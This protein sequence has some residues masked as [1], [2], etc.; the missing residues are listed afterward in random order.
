ML[1]ILFRPVILLWWL[2][3]SILFGQ[4]YLIHNYTADDG[5]P[6]SA[7]YDVIQDSLGQI[8]AATRA[9][10]AINNGQAWQWTP[11]VAKHSSRHFKYFVK[12]SAGRLMLVRQ[13]K[14][15][16]IYNYNGSRWNI[17]KTFDLPS[18]E[19]SQPNKVAVAE[20][21]NKRFC[22]I[23]SYP[24][25]VYL[26]IRNQWQ[27]LMLSDADTLLTVNAL[28]PWRNGWFCASNLG[29]HY[30]SV[31]GRQ[32]KT[33]HILASA[34]PDCKAI[35]I[36]TSTPF[37][38]SF[39]TLPSLWLV[40]EGG[41]A[42]FE[43]D[44]LIRFGPPIQH[45]RGSPSSIAID[46]LGDVYYSNGIETWFVDKM[47]TKVTSIPPETGLLNTGMYIIFRDRENNMWFGGNR[48]LSKLISKRF[49]NFDERHGLLANEVSAILHAPDGSTYLGHL[50]GYT[51]LK[52]GKATAV[53]FSGLNLQAN[54]H[55]R[56]LD[57]E[58]DNLGNIW[59]ASS[60]AGLQKIRHNRILKRIKYPGENRRDCTSIKEDAQGNI[61]TSW[62]NKLARFVGGRLVPFK[63]PLL[64]FAYYRRIFEGRDS[65]V[66]FATGGKGLVAYKDGNWKL[67]RSHLETANNIFS[68]GDMGDRVWVG[69]L[70][71]LY[72]ISGD[73]LRKNRSHKVFIE[74]PTYFIATSPSGATWFGTD[75]GVLRF[76][77]TEMRHYTRRHGL[78]GLETNRAAGVF[79]DSGHLWIGTESGVSV[80]RDEFDH[81]PGK[82]PL[83][84]I[85][86]M[87]VNGKLAKTTNP[88]VLDREENSL[89]FRFRGISFVDEKS[90]YYQVRLDGY[91]NAAFFTQL[92]EVRYK[93]LPQGEY[94]LV[95]RAAN[96]YGHWS[97]PAST[98]TIEV[99]QAFYLRGWFLF[100]MFSGISSLLMLGLF[101]YSKRQ[102]V[103]HLEEKYDDKTTALKESEEKYRIL[104]ESSEDLLFITSPEGQ[105]LD[106]NPAGL[107]L[108]GY[109]S[110][111][112]IQSIDLG[113]DLLAEAHLLGQIIGELRSR[114]TIENQEITLKRK[115]GE[116]R[117]F[118]TTA[119]AIYDDTGKLHVYRGIMRDI[120]EQRRL[121][122]QLFLSEKMKS[123]G[124]LAGGIAHDFN[125]ILSSILGYASLLK[126]ELQFASVNFRYVD[127]IEKSA[128]RAAELTNQ[129]LA[130][131]RG[132]KYENQP[133]D[134]NL[135][136]EET[137]AMVR[138]TFNRAIEI[139]F[140]CHPGPL[141]VEGDASQLQQ[142]IMNLCVN[143]RDALPDGG[144]IHLQTCQTDTGE[145]ASGLAT[146]K[147]VDNGVGIPKKDLQRI[148][149]PFYTT[150]ALR[151]GTGLG[152][153]MVYGV[154]KNH[155]G[156]I[157][158]DSSVGKGTTFNITLPL[159][160]RKPKAVAREIKPVENGEGTILVVD[161]E[162]LL[163]NFLRDGLE[164]AGYRVLTA[165]N[166][167][168]ALAT[169][170]SRGKEIDLIILDMIMPKMDGK[171]VI[172]QLREDALPA[173]VLLS[174]GY[175]NSIAMEETDSYIK[176]VL[177]KPFKLQTLL[178]KV[179]S[180][181]K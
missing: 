169:Y 5:L 62:D 104:F 75:N 124:L 30:I 173:K 163:R 168:E 71:G 140:D 170:H 150:K 59:L 117:H 74:N 9:G 135:L 159:S 78:I 36:D 108:L 49:A 45:V 96:L 33:K 67:F 80:Y 120:T 48:G 137:I 28:I 84:H 128:T 121:E 82:P 129:L 2:F 25:G 70:D 29:L 125:N 146:L 40:D 179:K 55:S 111:K 158:V 116:L 95:I 46:A 73:S 58:Q 176:G 109:P 155:S 145:A 93:N 91:D 166:G 151:K 27:K 53:E 88:V 18:L 1:P 24:E 64:P 165:E 100:L 180:A 161:D 16:E 174:T 113:K 41:I 136:V 15:L 26:N 43:N 77:G 65:T 87:E 86:E 21:G 42:L 7:V 118:L 99:K 37:N 126:E 52:D 10:L 6:S 164:R 54:Q 23:A 83:V 103:K 127:V 178:S 106:I 141:V 160:G 12:N 11:N 114:N 157:T 63:N 110:L 38:K 143:A 167:A 14:L 101:L 56:V 172:H 139:N 138:R 94:R 181:L 147:I 47:T 105:I 115:D 81:V 79:D 3:T 31:E 35:A 34:I 68:L 98:A 149:E 177:L 130:F 20:F 22:V 171:A 90:L 72:Y 32:Y 144:M 132:G 19:V 61:W 66:Y 119:S 13:Q 107:R 8:W 133:V 85:S 154:V 92:P 39:A 156:E 57:I 60:G 142:M 123:I 148:F 152:L 162:D 51:W 122:E 102:Y 131:A 97:L 112:D 4:S 175:S 76:D 153:S 44:S 134:L 50:D 69:T 89:T 17:Q